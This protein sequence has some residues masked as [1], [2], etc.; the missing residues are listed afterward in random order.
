M[1][2]AFGSPEKFG[3]AMDSV[4]PLVCWATIETPFEKKYSPSAT[5]ISKSP[6][7]DE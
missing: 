2:R 1:K 4:L 3:P 6:G 7:F 5:Q